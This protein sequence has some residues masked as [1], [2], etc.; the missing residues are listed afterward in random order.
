MKF[1]ANSDNKMTINGSTFVDG[2]IQENLE[3]DRIETGTSKNGNNFIALYWKDLSGAE[4][5]RTEW[6]PRI[7]E[8]E[9]QEILQ[10]KSDKIMKRMYHMLVDSGI[11]AESEWGFEVASFE[12]LGKELIARVIVPNKHKNKKVRIKVVYDDNNYTTL[13]AYT[14]A[15][16]IEPM[17]VVSTK[18]RKLGIDRFERIEPSTIQKNE[19]NPFVTENSEDNVTQPELTDD[20]P[21]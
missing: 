4:V 14:T 9:T 1:K 21:F 7:R 19:E 2:G 13:P 3:L 20:S 6:E 10:Q 15:V 12:E 5:S 16:W 17:S 11:L 8:G 18:M